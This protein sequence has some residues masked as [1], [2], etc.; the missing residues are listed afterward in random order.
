VVRQAY[1]WAGGPIPAILDGE[2]V[3]LGRTA[4]V[5]FR[6]NAFRALVPRGVGADA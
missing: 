5:R 3:Q 6:P 4:V 2:S 1:A